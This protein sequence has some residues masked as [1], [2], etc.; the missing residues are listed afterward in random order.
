MFHTVVVHIRFIGAIKAIAISLS[1]ALTSVAQNFHSAYTLILRH[2][3]AGTILLSFSA[4]TVINGSSVFHFFI[5]FSI[6]I[7][8]IANELLLTRITRQVLSFG[9]FNLFRG[10]FHIALV[11]TLPL[12]TTGT[13]TAFPHQFRIFTDFYFTV[14]TGFGHNFLLTRRRT[15]IVFRHFC[16]F[17]GIRNRIFAASLAHNSGFTFA[18]NNFITAIYLLTLRGLIL[19]VKIIY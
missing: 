2:R 11:T 7:I 17:I 9:R 4:R 13:R 3:A 6:G 1:V 5:F 8:A 18:I 12:F 16:R 14:F 10:H 19:A 15:R